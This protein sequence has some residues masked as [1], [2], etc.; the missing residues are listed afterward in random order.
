MY[1][2]FYQFN[3]SLAEVKQFHI[4]PVI[5]WVSF[6]ENMWWLKLVGYTSAIFYE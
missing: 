4:D 3:I 6:L 1:F 2:F 5:E